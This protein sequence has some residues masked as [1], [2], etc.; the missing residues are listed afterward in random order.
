MPRN[1]D[2]AVYA[3]AF[4]QAL[5]S[6]ARQEASLDELRSRTGTLVAAAAIAA[7]FLGASA[8]S[9]GFGL[10]GTLGIF[11]FIASGTLSLVILLPFRGWVF[12]DNIDTLFAGYIEAE[13]PADIVE[14]HRDLARN[15][16]AHIARNE[17]LLSRLYWAFRV[18]A[19]LLVL[20]VVLMLVDL[21]K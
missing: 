16:A 4:D 3:L 17:I 15:H 18:A 19:G 1:D 20:Q 10:A 9:N 21:A 6:L 7:S 2:P 8:A 13:D 11:A 12:D 5:R 14:I